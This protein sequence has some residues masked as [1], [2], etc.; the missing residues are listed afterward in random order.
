MSVAPAVVASASAAHARKSRPKKVAESSP[1]KEGPVSHKRK[2]P[3]VL[4]AMELLLQRQQKDEKSLESSEKKM[5][6][7]WAAEKPE[8]YVLTHP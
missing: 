2:A 8:E 7:K 1:A 3:P 6:E 4:T 5:L